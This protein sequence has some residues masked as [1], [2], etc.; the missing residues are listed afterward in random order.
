[1][2]KQKAIIIDLDGTLTINPHRNKI[3]GTHR[4]DFEP[5]YKH[6]PEDVAQEWCTNII[7]ELGF[8]NMI[9]YLTARPEQTRAV[10]SEWLIKNVGLDFEENALL[11]MMPDDYP[12]NKSDTDFKRI[13]INKIKKIY[14]VLFAIDDNIDNCL[15]FEEEGIKAL[16]CNVKGVD[17]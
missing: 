5:L 4:K 10:T 7:E 16:H 3:V 15:M 9:I 12:E 11:V 1:M 17:D 6:I 13:M 2:K 14:N 8:T